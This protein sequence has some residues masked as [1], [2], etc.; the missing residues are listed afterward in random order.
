MAMSFWTNYVNCRI[1]TKQ[2]RIVWIRSISCCPLFNRTIWKWVI[3]RRLWTSKSQSENDDD[4]SF[5]SIDDL[6]NSKKSSIVKMKNS[7]NMKAHA[8]LPWL[9]RNSS[10]I[11]CN[12]L[13]FKRNHL[14]LT[15]KLSNCRKSVNETIATDPNFIHCSLLL[16]LGV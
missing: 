3:W 11:N 8:W 13:I 4:I 10:I 7:I 9:K 12:H 14:L 2:R 15:H 6:E 1:L 16:L 5:V